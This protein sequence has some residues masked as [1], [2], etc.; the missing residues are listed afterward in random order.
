M[1]ELPESIAELVD[2]LTAAPGT[3]AVV[4]GGSRAIG[5]SDAAS[6]WDLGVYY[7]GS[8]DLTAWTAR[9][10]IYPPGC[11]GRIM[12]GG[13]WLRCGDLKVDVILRDLDVVEHWTR[14]AERGEFEV[15]LLSINGL[16]DD[17]FFARRTGASQPRSIVRPSRHRESQNSGSRPENHA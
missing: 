11:W 1:V 7:R 16:K 12:N 13:A 4:L 17:N 14:R 6:D 2:E 8:I 15:D 9:G 3:I 10:T 5:T